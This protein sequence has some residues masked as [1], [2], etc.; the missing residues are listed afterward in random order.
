MDST[1]PMAELGQFQRFER[2]IQALYKLER[3]IDQSHETS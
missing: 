2:D 1:W 3:A